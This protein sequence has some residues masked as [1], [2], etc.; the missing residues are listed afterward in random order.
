MNLGEWIN[1]RRR[2]NGIDM[3]QF[4][5]TVGMNH[6]SISRIEAGETIPTLETTVKIV[7]ALG[8]NE[9]ELLQ[10]LGETEIEPI[11]DQDG[12]YITLRDIEK[13]ERLIE[14]MPET[15]YLLFSNLVNIVA[16]NH[17]GM[18]GVD[19]DMV[20]L[21]PENVK[22]LFATSPLFIHSTVYPT[23]MSRQSIQDILFEN[24]AVLP[25]DFLEYLQLL[26]RTT[27][28]SS[29]NSREKQLLYKINY[30]SPFKDSL[31]KIKFNVLLEV[32]DVFSDRHKIFLLS[33]RS[34]L[35]EIFQSQRT[36]QMFHVSEKIVAR[37]LVIINRWLTGP[38]V[39]PD[40]IQQF[41]MEMEK[42]LA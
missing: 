41:R 35:F 12:R 15:A 28:N 24:G 42:A 17:W 31:G 8:S 2:R 36:E 1:L 27:E 30:S 37:S 6:S 34:A 16:E 9:F 4:G 11:P 22:R 5:E 13:F 14:V 33:W 7:R 39:N 40:L 3:R 18:K 29:S 25:E 19:N 21:S 10:G 23:F 32:D 38:Q 26:E 20:R